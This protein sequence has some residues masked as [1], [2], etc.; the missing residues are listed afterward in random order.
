[1]ADCGC[2]TLCVDLHDAVNHKEI[3]WHLHFF[4]VVSALTTNSCTH[5]F[6]VFLSVFVCLS[7]RPS[8]FL[9]VKFFNSW[10]PYNIS[11]KL[12]KPDVLAYQILK[13][14][15]RDLRFSQHFYSAF[16]FSRTSRC[17]IGL[18]ILDVSKEGRASIFKS[19]EL[20]DQPHTVASQ[21]T[22]MLYNGRVETSN[23]APL[24]Y[25][26]LTKCTLFFFGATA[27]CVSWPPWWFHFTDLYPVLSSTMHSLPRS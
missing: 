3:L 7:V 11:M 4:P 25:K 16:R 21:N 22:W 2:P 20:Q 15:V 5:I 26:I 6:L 17:V 13:S 8:F 27:S 12:Y 1:M 18:L 24:M 23:F 9:S 14:R 19:A 10:N